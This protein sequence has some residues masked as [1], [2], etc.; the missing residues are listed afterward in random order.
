MKFIKTKDSVK[1]WD[2]PIEY[3]QSSWTALLMFGYLAT[4]ADPT[5]WLAMGLLILSMGFWIKGLT[6]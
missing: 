3:W 6:K 1:L 4:D 2:I 5:S